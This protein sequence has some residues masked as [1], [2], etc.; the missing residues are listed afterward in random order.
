MNQPIQHDTQA[1]VVSVPVDS[2]CKVG[3][4]DELRLVCIA[5]EM[6]I[7]FRY[8]GFSHEV[9]IATPDLR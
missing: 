4:I 3:D 8:N 5:E 2:I 1:A 6:P 9:M 7:A